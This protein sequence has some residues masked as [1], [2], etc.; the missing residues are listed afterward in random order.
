MNAISKIYED[1][2]KTSR[3]LVLITFIRNLLRNIESFED[4]DIHGDHNTNFLHILTDT[5]NLKPLLSEH[6]HGAYVH[7]FMQ[8]TPTSERLARPSTQ[9][10]ISKINHFIL[11]KY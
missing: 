8:R 7:S 2:A 6:F 11:K 9:S 1:C 4:Y 10:V 5:L 3:K